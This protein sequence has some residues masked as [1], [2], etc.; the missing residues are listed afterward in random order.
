MGTLALQG[1]GTRL[2]RTS[3]GLKRI[4]LVIDD[5]HPQRLNRTSVGLKLFLVLAVSLAWAL[6]QSNQRGIET[7]LA[8][9]ETFAWPRLN[10][11][12]VGLKP[13]ELIGSSWLKVG[14]QSN[15]RGIETGPGCR[16][17]DHSTGRLNR[18]SVGLK[19]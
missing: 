2:N 8:W 10:R 16:G 17:R 14:P 13:R 5:P 7:N 6:P 9:A 15:Q 19:Q 11:T 3:V 1:D 12:S 4:G 18:T